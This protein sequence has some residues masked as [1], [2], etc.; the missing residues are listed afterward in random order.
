MITCKNIAI[1]R[2][3]RGLTQKELA[4]L[5]GVKQQHISRWECGKHIPTIEQ[6]VSI[7][8]ALNCSLDVLYSKIEE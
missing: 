1:E 2:A 8:E 5:A 6:L 4:E 3:K 7:A